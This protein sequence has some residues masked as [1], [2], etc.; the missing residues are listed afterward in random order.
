MSRNNKIK[1]SRQ[2]S[3]PFVE[4]P[5]HVQSVVVDPVLCAPVAAGCGLGLFSVLLLGS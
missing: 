4:A 1:S 5:E 2:P 3:T